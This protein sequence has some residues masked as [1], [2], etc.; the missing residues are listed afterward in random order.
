MLVQKANT[1][2]LS[3]GSAYLRESAYVDAYGEPDFGF[4]FEIIPNFVDEDFLYL[5]LC[6]R[7]VISKMNGYFIKLTTR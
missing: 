3:D 6:H 1:V 7:L 5:F 2:Y 4:K